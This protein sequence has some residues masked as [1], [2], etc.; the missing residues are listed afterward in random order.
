MSRP[1]LNSDMY[2][3]QVT[4]RDGKDMFVGMRVQHEE[5][6]FPLAQKINEMSVTQRDADW[7][8]ARV[9]CIPAV[10]N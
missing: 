9:V 1:N 5:I 7:R 10:I 6:L 8:N 3:V 2:Q 4:T